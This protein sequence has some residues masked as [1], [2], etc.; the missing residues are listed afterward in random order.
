MYAYAVSGMAM[1]KY[2][3]GLGVVW[4]WHDVKNTIANRMGMNNKFLILHIFIAQR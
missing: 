1:R 4:R 3:V 2:P